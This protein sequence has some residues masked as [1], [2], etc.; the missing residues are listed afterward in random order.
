MID[1]DAVL[2]EQPGM[3]I[4]GAGF[5]VTQTYKL[6]KVMNLI[7]LINWI[8]GDHPKV[9]FIK[10]IKSIQLVFVDRMYP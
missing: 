8:V 3:D 9:K 10:L 5:N 1:K 4:F 7:N 6:I 2:Q